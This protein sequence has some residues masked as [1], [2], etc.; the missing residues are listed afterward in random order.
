MPPRGRELLVALYDA[1]VVGVAPGPL[2]TAALVSGP[3]L[4]RTHVLALGKASHAMAAAAAA[5]VERQGGALAGGVVVAADEAAVPAHAL[6]PTIGDHPVPHARS[7]AAAARL[8]AAVARVRPDDAA[9]VL[10]SGG[11]TS[12]VA[13]PTGGLSGA[14]LTR[15]FELLHRAGLDI[16]AMNVV[17][18]RFVQW[19]AGRLA[20]AL[21]AART[22][23]LII[24]DVPGDDPADVASGPCTPDV[25]TADEV[26]AIL[27]DHGLFAELP[28]A[29]RDYLDAVRRGRLPETP[30]PGDAVFERVHTEVIGTNAVAVNAAVTRALELGLTGERG[31]PFLTG[32]AAS[33]GEALARTLL[34]RAA[35]GWRGCLVWG[36]ETTV[37]R[38]AESASEAGEQRGGRCQEL[39]L[40]AA[41]ALSRARPH[42]R[43]VTMLAAGTDGRDGPT[44]AAGAF[45]D[46]EVWHAVERSGRDP[47]HDLARHR[48]YD[49]LHAAGALLRARPTGTNVMDVVIGVVE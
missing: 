13:A 48:S 33:S 12:L 44:D 14:D 29:L 31:E 17:R 35:S 23:V 1:A 43:R 27:H 16:H 24:S 20:T 22:R 11:A 4:P 47:A 10:L 49:A 28:S 37:R 6:E 39:A 26:T 42:G 38:T 46:A 7:F 8:G 36:G 30:K 3:P 15:L 32:E 25:A 19:G 2:T 40:S 5:F 34:E 45:A 9:L 18:K 41:R 21:A